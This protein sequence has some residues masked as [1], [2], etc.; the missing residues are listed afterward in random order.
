MG[1]RG[2]KGVRINFVQEAGT[3]MR[4]EDGWACRSNE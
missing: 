4:I 1:H 3:V 2:G